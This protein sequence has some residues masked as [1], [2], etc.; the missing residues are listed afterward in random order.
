MLYDPSWV[1]R[2]YTDPHVALAGLDLT[3]A[4]RHCWGA[5]CASVEGRSGIVLIEGYNRCSRILCVRS[6]HLGRVFI[7]RC[8]VSSV[9]SFS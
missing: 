6:N 9:L 1:E 3:E 8:I 7:A 4:E 2:V 5:G